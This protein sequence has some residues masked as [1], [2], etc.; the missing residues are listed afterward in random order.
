MMIC[1]VR[2]SKKKA[3]AIL[4]AIAII[5][6]AVILAMPERKAAAGAM[7]S[8]GGIRTEEDRAAYLGSLGYQVALPALEQK[9]VVIPDRFDE[10]YTAYNEMQRDCGFDL[11]D[12][13]GREVDLYTYAVT[14]DPRDK[15]VRC[16]LLVCGGRIVGGNI[17]TTA[18]D[19]FMHGLQPA[20][21]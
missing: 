8:V 19:G 15:D 16:D 4:L 1:T 7:G 9:T 21:G 6:A 18:L 14:N 17:Y 10:V 12:Y 13:R 11:T 2:F 3:V 5:L 20:E